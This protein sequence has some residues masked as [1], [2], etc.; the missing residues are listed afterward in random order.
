MS[1]LH[2][3]P[4]VKT[5]SKKRLGRGTGSGKG[6]HTVGR[7]QKGQTSRVGKGI[8]H[9]FEGGQ[10]P[11]SKRMPFIR[12]KSRFKS[13][14]HVEQLVTLDQLSTLSESAV[15]PSVLKKHG[16]IRYEDQPVKLTA[17]GSVKKAFT[18]QGIS[19]TLTA[20]AQIEKAGGRIE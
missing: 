8:P 2:S 16:F 4:A 18:I 17:I 6:N 19:L 13:L 15:T 1:G 3:L 14:K 7:G 12:G 10:L 11:L 20:K 9:W 5:R